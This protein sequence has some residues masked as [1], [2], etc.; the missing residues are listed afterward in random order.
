MTNKECTITGSDLRAWRE[1]L[2]KDEAWIEAIL[3]NCLLSGFGLA[4]N[5]LSRSERRKATEGDA[6]R[7]AYN[8]H[9][10]GQM[11]TAYRA[12]LEAEL[13]L[14]E[15][16]CPERVTVD[17]SS[18][19]WKVKL[20]DIHCFS[21]RGNTYEYH[22]RFVTVCSEQHWPPYLVRYAANLSEFRA[23]VAAFHAASEKQAKLDAVKAAEAAAEKAAQKA[24]AA[25]DLR[26]ETFRALHE[27]RR[28]L[29]NL[30]KNHGA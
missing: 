26:D 9:E 14:L 25:I 30:E 2:G 11:T 3:G 16:V 23:T 22:D 6:M 5:P 29:T 18:D 7:Y 27:A 17:R 19:T 15:P 13:T 21:V 1:K 20:N 10:I 8:T 24:L 28:E 4:P 12:A